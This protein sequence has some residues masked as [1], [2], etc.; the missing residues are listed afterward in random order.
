MA[1]ADE[2]GFVRRGGY[3]GG[4]GGG[5]NKKRRFREDDDY[6]RQPQR[7]RQEETPWRRVRRAILSIAES[8]ALIFPFHLSHA[9]QSI[10]LETPRR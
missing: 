7:R 4:G 2:R 9:D 8:V 3:N 6:A 5:G 1:D 10:A